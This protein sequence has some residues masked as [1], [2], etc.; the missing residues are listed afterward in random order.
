MTLA[1]D[2][3]LAR[4]CQLDRSEL[5]VTG[6][7]VGGHDDAVWR[8]VALQH[9]ETR[10][11]R[12]LAKQTLSGSQGDRENLEP[13]FVDQIIL[14]QRLNQVAASV[15]LELGAVS[16]LELLDLADDIAVDGDGLLPIG[17]D[18]AV[19]DDIFRRPIDR[20]A[21]RVGRLRPKTGKDVVGLPAQEQIEG[22]A[23]LLADRLA[24]GVIEKG[25][26]PPPA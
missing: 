20:L 14:E 7:A 2:Y 12:A 22:M 3:L 19:R 24:D 25:H 9:A 21:G 5:D 13:E 6:A 8:D 15:H 1:S 26:R 4:G 11:L 23:H 10:W 18:R 16:L 17:A